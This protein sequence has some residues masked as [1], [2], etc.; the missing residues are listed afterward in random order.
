MAA[1]GDFV[2]FT[3]S[4]QP[5]VLLNRPDYAA[6]VFV[7]RVSAFRKGIANRRAKSLLGEGLL[8]A[9]GAR[10]TESRRAIQP[11]F[12]RQRLESC[13]S[14]I[15]DRAR[16]VRGAW[17]PGELVDVTRSMGALTF[18]VVG[19]VIVGARVDAQFDQ[20]RHMTETAT[21]T[22][23]PLLSLIAPLRRI[24]QARARLRIVATTLLERASRAEEGSLLALLRQHDPEPAVQAQRVD[25]LVTLLLAGHDTLTSALTWAWLLLAS[26]PDVETR[27]HDELA[28]V[29]GGRNATAA[30]VSALPLTKAVLAEALRLYPP[31]WVLA[32]QAVESQPFDEGEIAAGALVLVSPYVMHRD[33]RWFER[34]DRFE[35]DRWLGNQE[36]PKTAYMPFGAGPRSCIGESFAWLEGVLILATIAQRWKLTMV[37]PI[38]EPDLRITLRPRG[39]V[40]LR[41]CPQ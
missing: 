33:A 22:I 24:R 21:A 15:V 20:V 25:H 5:A 26:H 32:R 35:P 12:A 1:K 13:A 16:E 17:R 39:N 11:V 41:A 28:T 2:R 29:L 9:E 30:D 18:G 27:L 37:G 31:A 23:D 10:H 6:E 40:F 14:V 34:P 19:E 4:R 8:T 38:A 3:L 36:R 7:S